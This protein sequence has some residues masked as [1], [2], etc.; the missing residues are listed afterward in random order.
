MREKLDTDL[1]L[2]KEK[3]MIRFIDIRDQG[4]GSRFAFFNTTKCKLIEINGSNV[5]DNWKEFEA[6]S[7]RITEP[8]W[9]DRF[10]SLCPEWA[11]N[12]E[13]DALE[14]W[15]AGEVLSPH[16][17][18]QELETKIEAMKRD[19]ELEQLDSDMQKD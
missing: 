12:D 6:D 14:D 3:I 18:I 2:T 7:Y 11:F 15:C 10:K 19:I 4:T 8:G 1:L 13:Q 9:L 17:K 5:W 16:E